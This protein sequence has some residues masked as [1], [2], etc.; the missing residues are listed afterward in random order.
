M[1]GTMVD[2]IPTASKTV[3]ELGLIKPVLVVNENFMAYTAF[4]LMEEK[5]LFRFIHTADSVSQ[6]KNVSGVG[7]VNAEGKLIGCISVSDI[8]LL[9]WNMEYWSMLGG[10]VKDY[11]QQL[12]ARKDYRI[13]SK[14]L[15]QKISEQTDFPIVLTCQPQNTLASVIKW[16]NMHKIHRYC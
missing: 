7:V 1:I 14:P 9:G 8:K 6:S 15:I 13:M 12:A 5:V 16:I 3:Q 4:K 2:D 11:L 10:S